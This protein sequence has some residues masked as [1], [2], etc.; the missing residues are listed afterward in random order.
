MPLPFSFTSPLEPSS[1]PPALLS[2]PLI[3]FPLTSFLITQQLL[4]T[5][6]VEATPSTSL[7]TLQLE[8]STSLLLPFVSMIE[9]QTSSFSLP[10]SVLT[11]DDTS[12]SGHR[13]I[14]LRNQ[15]SHSSRQ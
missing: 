14:D 12:L 7:P 9:P 1:P 13:H 10:T 5:S 11:S 2:S 8:T 6:P 4:S 3:L 15:L